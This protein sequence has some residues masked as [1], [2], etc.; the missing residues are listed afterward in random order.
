[1]F[2]NSTVFRVVSFFYFN[3][4]V[5]SFRFIRQQFY[6]SGLFRWFQTLKL[7]IFWLKQR[8]I[9]I[10]QISRL[11][12]FVDFLEKELFAFKSKVNYYGISGWKPVFEAIGIICMAIVPVFKVWGWLIL[13]PVAFLINLSGR[14]KNQNPLTVVSS[15][16]WLALLIS[17]VFSSSLNSGWLYLSRYG[18]YLILFWLVGK[19]SPGYSRRLILYLV[20]SSLIWLVLGLLQQWAGIPTPSG[21]LS[22]EQSRVITLRVYSLFTNPNTYGLYLL[23]NLILVSFLL[24]EFTGYRRL[25]LIF[26]GF[27]TLLSLYLT[28]SRIA[29]ILGT[30]FLIA[31]YW[32]N[33][34]GKKWLIVGAFLLLLFALE[35]L[36]ARSLP[37]LLW[38][39][40]SLR[41]RFRIWEGTIKAIAAFW[42]WGAGP[43]S[44]SK[45]YP[46]FQNGL[47]PA[48]HSHQLYL[49]LW[50]ENGIFSLGVFIF[51]VKHFFQKI[52]L[53]QGLGRS[54][55]VIVIMFLGYGL[56]ES[57][58]ESQ[59]ISGYFW[60]FAGLTVSL[61]L[62]QN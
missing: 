26:I 19:F 53:V 37:L 58:F 30:F 57:W 51:W 20:C 33:P 8:V 52:S 16:L 21:W 17:A 7:L 9:I 11:R 23:S 2:A 31:K 48:D 62:A 38:N 4:I 47:T 25:F 10:R 60:L 41:Y 39:D 14:E 32:R 15:F 42:L 1:M 54:C 13:I 43:G 28:Y 44:F 61:N 5:G 22:E 55:M 56:F 12:K 29:W 36:K 59:L 46:W 40:S 6:K 35:A 34:A 49:Q 3:R 18:T 50:L 45:I 24:K 27:L